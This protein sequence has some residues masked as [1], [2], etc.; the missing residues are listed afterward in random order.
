M[1]W[2]FWDVIW[3][4]LVVFFWITFLIIFFN[5]V[6]DV[7]RSH[8][9][10]GI[11]KAVWLIVLVVLP[12]LGVLIYTIVRGSGMAERAIRAQGEQAQRVRAAMAELATDGAGPADQIAKAKDLLDQGV[13]SQDEFAALK[14][15]ALA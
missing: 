15:K 8:D 10:S 6:V 2:S 4:T 12:L 1:D 11:K 13:I 9:L 5:T 14:A 7:F 3:T